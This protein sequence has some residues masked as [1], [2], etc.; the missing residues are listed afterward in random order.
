MCVGEQTGT[1][2]HSAL[3]IVAA[4]QST[5][6]F[7][8]AYSRYCEGR[9]LFI[10]TR[11]PKPIGH[12]VKF[13][14]ALASGEH[15]MTGVGP[16]VETF[17]DRDNR[18]NR[19]GMRIEVEKLDASGREWMEQLRVRSSG[20]AVPGSAP[21][22]ASSPTGMFS[23]I[24]DESAAMA[25]PPAAPT[26]PAA[27]AAKDPPLPAPANAVDKKA[28]AVPVAV[29]DNLSAGWELDGLSDALAPMRMPRQP[30]MTAI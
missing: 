9:S 24:S 27:R 5:A 13:K 11:S 20:A 3:R 17:D 14:I 21:R 1:Q 2:S 8:A 15:L 22:A 7:V 10:A 18:F 29:A 28:A 6:E 19:P 12:V 30:G 25:P 4:C 23:I 16:V 26:A